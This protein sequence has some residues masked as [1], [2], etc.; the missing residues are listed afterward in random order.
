MN[1]FGEKVGCIWSVA[2]RL[3]GFDRPNQY[4]DAML[5]RAQIGTDSKRGRRKIADM[6]AEVTE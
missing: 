5:P 1:D 2:D 3:H 4:E 6:L